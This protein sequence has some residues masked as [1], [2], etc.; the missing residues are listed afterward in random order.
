MGIPDLTP[1]VREGRLLLLKRLLDADDLGKYE[2]LRCVPCRI[3]S[4]DRDWHARD[5]RERRGVG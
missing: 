3:H 5:P 4:R 1:L 2:K